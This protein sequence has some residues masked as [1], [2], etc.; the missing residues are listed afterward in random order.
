[1]STNESYLPINTNGT[2][3]TI[4]VTDPKY[5]AYGDGVHDDTAAI[6]AALDASTNVYL[7]PGTYLVSSPLTLQDGANVRITGAGMGIT[8]IKASAAIAAVLQGTNNA[9]SLIEGITIDG[10][11]LATYGLSLTQSPETSTVNLISNVESTGATSYGFYLD[12]HEDTLLLQCLKDGNE[13]DATSLSPALYWNVPEGALFIVGGAFFGECNLGYQQA[14]ITDVTLGPIV[15]NNGSANSNFQMV[16]NGCYVYDGT[17]NCIDTT[18]NLT[19]IVING[20]YLVNQS[21]QAWINGNLLDNNTISLESTQFIM[22]NNTTTNVWLVKTSGAGTVSFSGCSTAI[23]SG[24]TG[25]AYQAVNG[26]TT[27]PRILT[28]LNGLALPSQ[29]ISP[30]ASPLVSGTVYQNTS[31]VPIAIY[32]PAYATASGTAGSVAVAIGPTSAPATLYTRQ[33]PGATTGTSP[34]V[35]TVRV[36]PGWYYSFTATGATLANAQMIGE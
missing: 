1:M 33:I 7:P 8:T 24:V 3:G 29:T 16:L 18:T 17:Y 28:A 19:N 14:S 10:N 30:P 4:V 2:P 23:P 20:S 31:S 15:V 27:Q 6:Q 13:A 25:A 36:P 32:Q 5:G 21:Q 12:G 11:D 22:S 9:H 26:G 34:D 35:C